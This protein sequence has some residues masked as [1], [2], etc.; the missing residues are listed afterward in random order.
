ME[1][2]AAAGTECVASEYGGSDERNEWRSHDCVRN[3][4]FLRLNLW[5]KKSGIALRPL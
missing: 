1:S 3:A 2:N 4:D 5:R